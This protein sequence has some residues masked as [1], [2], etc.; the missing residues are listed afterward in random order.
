MNV[1]KIVILNLHPLNYG[2]DVAITHF[3]SGDR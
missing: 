1:N 2:F 3:A